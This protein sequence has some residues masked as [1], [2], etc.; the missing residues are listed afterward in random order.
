MSVY[1][2]TYSI[3][4]VRDEILGDP[5]VFDDYIEADDF[6]NKLRSNYVHLTNCRCYD[7]V[8]EENLGPFGAWVETWHSDVHSHDC[9]YVEEE[10]RA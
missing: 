6:F 4:H 2:Y 3:T 7:I 5:F 1:T 10:A 8:F 9:K